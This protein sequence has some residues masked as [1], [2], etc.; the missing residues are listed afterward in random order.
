MEAE[1]VGVGEEMAGVVFH[2]KYRRLEHEVETAC[3]MLDQGRP[4]EAQVRLLAVIAQALVDI[5]EQM[6]WEHT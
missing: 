5:A 3:Y 6:A 2:A 1:E 4:E